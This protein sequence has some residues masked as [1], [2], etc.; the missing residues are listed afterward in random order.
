MSERELETFPVWDYA[1]GG[2][3]GKRELKNKFNQRILPEPVSRKCYS[4]STKQL[5]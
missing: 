2:F 5:E 4:F 1:S 3:R